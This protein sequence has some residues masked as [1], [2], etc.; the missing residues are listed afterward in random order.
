MRRPAGKHHK[1]FGRAALRHA[2]GTL[3]F[4]DFARVAT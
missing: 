1:S 4:L 3:I 2:L